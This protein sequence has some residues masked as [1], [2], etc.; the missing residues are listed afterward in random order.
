MDKLLITPKTKIY[1]LLEAYPQLEDVLIDIAPEFKKLK[2]PILRRTIARVTNISQ[3]AVVGNVPVD[4]IVR[5]LR[6][7]VGQ[8][9]NSEADGDATLQ[10]N[11]K[12]PEWY[13]GNKSAA[14]IDISEMLDRGEQPVHDVIAALNKLGDRE[15]LEVKA[16]FVPAP[17]L[18]KASSL[19][20]IH[21]M[22]KIDDSN[23]K[24][25]FSKE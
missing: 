7:A 17:L 15:I 10:Y 2:N 25:R 14:F 3:A 13:K 5:T 12:A 11:T 19:G 23:F 8:H 18:D 6:E 1:D 22:E 21:W 20:Y 24:I 4:K 9:G 16:P